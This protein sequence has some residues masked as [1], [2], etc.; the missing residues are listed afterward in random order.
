MSYG[1]TFALWRSAVG[2]HWPAFAG[3]KFV[4][5]LGDGTLPQAAFLHYKPCLLSERL[6]VGETAF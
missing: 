5:V 6:S 3:H 1:S 2:P 4:K